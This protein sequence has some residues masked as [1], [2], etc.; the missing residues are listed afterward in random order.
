MS[1]A[2]REPTAAAMRLSDWLHR[3]LIDLDGRPI[4]DYH[5]E[6][7]E[8][9]QRIDR[10]TKPEE[11]SDPATTYSTDELHIRAEGAGL[12]YRAG[13]IEQAECLRIEVDASLGNYSGPIKWKRNTEYEETL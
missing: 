7:R 8:L 10:E 13:L 11:K 12:L 1:D 6:I 3:N 2:D 4:T 9:A 5:E